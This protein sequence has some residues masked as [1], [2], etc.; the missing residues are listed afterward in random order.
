M[1]WLAISQA[2]VRTTLTSDGTLG[3]TVTQSGPVHTITGGTRP[4]NG[5]NLFHSFDRFS[6]GR[7]ETASFTSAQTGIKHILSRVT[8][9][10]RSDIDGQLRTDGQLRSEGAHV[11]LLN[12]SGVL[13]G[14]DASLDIT[15]SLHVSTADY[16]RLADGA[17]FFAHLA[18]TSVLSVAPPEAFGFLGPTPAPISL[19]DSILQV[20]PGQ[21]LA[22]IGGDVAIVGGALKAPSGRIHLASV[23]SPGEI[24]F[25]P[26]DLAPELQV[27]SGARLGWLALS[28]EA[29]V[30]VNS[31]GKQN[32]GGI[33]VRA[34]R[35]TLTGGAEISS[36]TQGEGQGG[37]VA[38]MA[39]EAVVIAGQGQNT[40]PSGLFSS[41]QGRGQGGDITVQAPR[42]ELTN[43]ATISAES[44]GPGNAGNVTLSLGDTFV[45]TKGSIV[46][47]AVQA[48]GGNIQ[49]TAPTV[50]VQN[51]KIVANVFGGFGG[52]VHI[53]ASII[54]IL[55][56]FSL[57]SASNLVNSVSVAPAPL[58]QEFAPAMELLRDRCA[59]RLR[60]GRVSHFVLGGRD[61]VPLE[62]G[63]LL[64]SSLEQV[65]QEEDSSGGTRAS[66]HPEAQPRQTWAA[67]APT[68]GEPEVACARWMGKPGL[69]EPR[70][71]S[72]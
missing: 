38:V 53:I 45:S 55:D 65:G 68:L 69:Q 8:G 62:P 19:Q 39:S 54:G 47:Q 18:Q 21:T 32:A 67:Q 17:K 7:G 61:G 70:K 40:K 36:S 42:V 57:V 59:G 13:F 12:P 49:I 30:T 37:N 71:R 4:G 72:R 26:P 60:E 3:T 51:S 24:R 31:T 5:P 33:A 48:G 35:L 2:Q 66:T 16:L 28:R 29:L 1:L 15:G 41:A 23:A 22:V 25:S 10:Q 63:G 46:T 43:R 27:D 9:G 64:L 56:P 34:G 14:P 52:N 11:Y 6:V 20:L 50:V 44:T 58:P